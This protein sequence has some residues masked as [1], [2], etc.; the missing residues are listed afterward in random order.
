MDQAPQKQHP[1]TDDK[2]EYNSRC[3]KCSHSIFNRDRGGKRI[4]KIGKCSVKNKYLVS[5]IS[6]PKFDCPNFKKMV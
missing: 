6:V 3:Q 1:F 4:Y 5:V 2:T